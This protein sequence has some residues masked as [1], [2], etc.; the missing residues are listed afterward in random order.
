MHK[1][2]GAVLFLSDLGFGFSLL[3]FGVFAFGFW[4]FLTPF[5]SSGFLLFSLSL[6]FLGEVL[7]AGAL[8]A[9]LLDVA[10]LGQG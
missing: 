8:A 1:G 6:L 2:F 4:L 9:F 5:F 7:L 3:G 10:C